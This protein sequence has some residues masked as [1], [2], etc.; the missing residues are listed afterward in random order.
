MGTLN[1]AIMNKKTTLGG[2][3]LIAHIVYIVLSAIAGEGLTSIPFEQVIMLG[4][5]ALT[6][7]GLLNAR[8]ADKTSEDQAA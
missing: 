3:A 8:D 4:A 5:E 6:A 7:F 1:N 2:I